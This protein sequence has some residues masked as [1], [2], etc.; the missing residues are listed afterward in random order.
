MADGNT[1]DM[2]KAKHLVANE[3]VI[4]VINKSIYH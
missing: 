2:Q 1:C 3:S 4:Y